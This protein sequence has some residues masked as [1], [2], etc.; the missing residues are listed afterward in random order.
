MGKEGLYVQVPQRQILFLWK[1]Q[2]Q[3]LQYI[4]PSGIFILG[5][6]SVKV[7]T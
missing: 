6:C 3:Q 1:H 2:A 4:A 7:F 5:I